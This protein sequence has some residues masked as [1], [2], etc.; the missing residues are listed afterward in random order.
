MSLC[1]VDIMKLTIT[2]K[3]CVISERSSEYIEKQVRKL[4]Q[5]LPDFPTDGVSIDIMVEKQHKRSAIR[6]DKD[7]KELSEKNVHPIIDHPVY[8]EVAIKMVLPVKPLIVASQGKSV[9]EA[10]KTGFVRLQRMLQQYKGKY[11][12]DFTE[13]YDRRTIRKGEE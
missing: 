4:D 1:G 8:F 6:V 3:H 9:D 11:F 12:K 5:F 7:K 2:A 13:Y 10:V